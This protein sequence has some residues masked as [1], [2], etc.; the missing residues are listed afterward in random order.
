MRIALHSEIRDGAVDDYRSH[1][2]RIPDDLATTFARIGI[3]GWT[4]WRPDLAFES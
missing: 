3:H 1:H 4:I 2:A